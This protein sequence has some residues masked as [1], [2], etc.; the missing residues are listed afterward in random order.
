[1]TRTKWIIKVTLR[2]CCSRMSPSESQS[3][4]KV[5]YTSTSALKRYSNTTDMTSTTLHAIKTTGT[6]LRQPT[7]DHHH[8]NGV[9]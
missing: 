3:Q 1:M 2:G 9:Y 7:E 8:V 6:E 4:I 5:L